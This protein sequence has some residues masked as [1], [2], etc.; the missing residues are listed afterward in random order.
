[1]NERQVIFAGEILSDG[2]GGFGPCPALL[3]EAEAIRF[4]RLDTQKA[5]P[6][7]TLAHYRDRKL[8]KT[9]VVG[10]NLFYTRKSLVEFL[11]RL[12]TQ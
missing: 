10:K 2:K 11:D 1:M 5:K 9:T 4:L 12:T 6:E 3:T 8:L 7:N